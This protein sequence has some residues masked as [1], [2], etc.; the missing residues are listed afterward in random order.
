MVEVM[1]AGRL[2][3]SRRRQRP[4]Y[5]WRGVNPRRVRDARDR[6]GAIR[7]A[8]G[9]KLT[10]EGVI[11]AALT[12][13]AG[14]R[15]ESCHRAAADQPSLIS[16]AA[17]CAFSKAPMRAC[18]GSAGLEPAA[19]RIAVDW[20]IERASRGRG[21]STFAPDF[22]NELRIAVQR[23][24]PLIR[25]RGKSGSPPTPRRSLLALN[26]FAANIVAAML[27]C[28]VQRRSCLL[29]PRLRFRFARAAF[30]QPRRRAAS[31]IAER[32]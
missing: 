6:E 27:D 11:R 9:Y 30:L 29:S 15:E 4:P 23:D 25:R 2:N 8:F 7:S 21:A 3:T 10:K 26:A 5:G 22:P 18:R 20:P 24:C 14:M 16:G 17:N 31:N 28:C 13:R 19:E 12:R 1:H 32:R